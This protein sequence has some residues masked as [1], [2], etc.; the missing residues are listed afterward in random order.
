[1]AAGIWNFRSLVTVEALPLNPKTDDVAAYGTWQ[2]WPSLPDRA[3]SWYSVS[4][5]ALD[6]VLYVAGNPKND[7][8][9]KNDPFAVM[10]LLWDR[11]SD[12]QKPLPSTSGRWLP[13]DALSKTLT[14]GGGSKYLFVV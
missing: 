11:A 12:S 5:V 8:P 14:T 10:C 2:E 1:M 6:Y 9:Y 3:K 4:F 13:I 7:D